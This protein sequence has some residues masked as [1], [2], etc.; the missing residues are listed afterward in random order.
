MAIALEE[1]QARLAELR[2]PRTPASLPLR[3]AYGLTLTQDVLAPISQ[4]PFPIS[5]LDGY[6]LRAEDTASATPARPVCLAVE[7]QCLPGDPMPAPVERG[8]AV[9]VMTGSPIPMGADCVVRQENVTV[10]ETAIFLRTPL[11]QWE[12]YC[13]AG[14]E[15]QKGALLL[16]KGMELDAAALALAAGAGITELSVVRPVRVAVLST[17]EELV[18]PGVPLRPGQLYEE[19]SV[20]LSARIS[21]LGGTVVE[22]CI[23]PDRLELLRQA[24]LEWSVKADVVIVTGGVSVGKTDLV[25]QALQQVGAEILFHGIAMKPGMPTLAAVLN[26]API[27]GLSGNPFAMAVA[28]ELLFPVLLGRGICRGRA[29]LDGSFSKPSPQR[30]FLGGRVEQ[31]RVTLRTTQENRQIRAMVGCNCLVE[32]AAGSPPPAPGADVTVVFLAAQ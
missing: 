8:K 9:Q 10:G 6:A 29:V 23:L 13:P 31:G 26:G 18:E 30:R 15:Y 17:G 28:F 3:R 14:S 11:Q 25:A 19:N 1:A 4:P 16:A 5:P 32:L 7:A 20:Y 24:L 21:Q 22:R 12:N 27:L 2:L